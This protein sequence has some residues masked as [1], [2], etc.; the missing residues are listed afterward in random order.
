[1]PCVVTSPATSASSL[2]ATGTHQQRRALAG[3]AAGVGGVGGGQRL[4][5]VH[6]PEGVE[7]R[8]E[9]LDAAEVEL[10]ELA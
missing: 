4:F 10:D 1:M 6:G 9:A 2:I 7:L 8:I 5:S 3:G